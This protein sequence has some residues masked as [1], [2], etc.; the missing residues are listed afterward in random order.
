MSIHNL[1]NIPKRTHPVPSVDIDNEE[2]LEIDIIS[3][4]DDD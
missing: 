3:I 4:S 1:W 2:E